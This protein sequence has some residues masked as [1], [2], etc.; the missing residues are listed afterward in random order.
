MSN[1]IPVS[2]VAG[3]NESVVKAG[4]IGL[5]SKLFKLN[6]GR[7]QLTQR[8][9]KG[10][11]ITPGR[12][13]IVETNQHFDEITAVMLIEPEPKRTM[14][15]VGA[16]FGAKPICYSFD[17]ETPAKTAPFPQALN[18]RNCK[19]A[20]WSKWQKTK[21]R[22]DLPPCGFYYRVTLVDRLTRFVYFLNVDGKSVK[23]FEKQYMQQLARVWAMANQMAE[24]EGQ[25][26]KNIF[27]FSMKVR[28]LSH[29]QGT[30]FTLEFKDFALIKEEDREKFGK[31]F[32]DFVGRKSNAVQDAIK[33][34]EQAV[35]EGVTEEGSVQPSSTQSN[36]ETIEI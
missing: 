22:K 6:P 25:P 3:S 20:D 4:G 13:R 28:P 33:A 23:P 24:A 31:I 15:P 14:Y 2:Q 12:I 5:G 17:A 18:C 10:E 16:P 26:P 36:G 21:D 8:M 27:D 11:T 19:Q 1:L 7:L 32:T 30:Y 34:D 9:T 29:D 35:D